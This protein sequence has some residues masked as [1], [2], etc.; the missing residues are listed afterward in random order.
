MCVGGKSVVSNEMEEN[1]NVA[2][3]DLKIAGVSWK[4]C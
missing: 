4:I 2:E 3:E 1:V